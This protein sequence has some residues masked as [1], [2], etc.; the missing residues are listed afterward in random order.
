MRFWP[1][2][3]HGKKQID[4]F[5]LKSH[6]IITLSRRGIAGPTAVLP[7]SRC[8]GNDRRCCP[9]KSCKKH[10]YRQTGGGYFS[11][12]KFIIFKHIKD[13]TCNH[14][15]VLWSCNVAS[16]VKLS[17]TSCSYWTVDVFNQ[18]CLRHF[19]C[20]LLFCLVPTLIEFMHLTQMRSGYILGFHQVLLMEFK[21]ANIIAVVSSMLLILSLNVLADIS[22]TFIVS[23]VLTV[24]CEVSLGDM[25]VLINKMYY[26]NHHV[27]SG[28]GSVSLT[29]F[30]FESCATLEQ[31][32]TY[33][34]EQ[35]VRA[36]TLTTRF[37][38]K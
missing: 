35:N 15:T 18:S 2:M 25:K 34:Q 28:S 21:P 8:W 14:I 27:V 23:T 9:S 19:S 5:R 30:C 37:F 38:N 22:F 4:I 12:Y 3:H 31:T 13:T 7:A 10:W 11:T 24:F 26:Y 33:T 36:C 6:Q 29:C 32:P 16:W 17:D 1:T 20:H